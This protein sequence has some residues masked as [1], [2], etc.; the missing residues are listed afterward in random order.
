MVR[1]LLS[2][3]PS[4]DG[5]LKIPFP[6]E[7]PITDENESNENLIIHI[8][9]D[10]VETDVLQDKSGNENKGFAIK[11]F[12]PKFENETLRVRKSKITSVIKTSTNNGA[13]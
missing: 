5:V 10:K 4:I 2:G 3:Y 8:I 1:W 11:D 7:G 9:N 6:L 13:F 12:S